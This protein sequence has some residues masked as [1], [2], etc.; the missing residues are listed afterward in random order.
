MAHSIREIN[1]TNQ[2]RENEATNGSSNTRQIESARHLLLLALTV[3]DQWEK[4]IDF[5]IIIHALL[6]TA[7]VAIIYLRRLGMKS[8]NS[9][10]LL[11]LLCAGAN[12]VL[13]DRRES[14]NDGPI[15]NNAGPSSLLSSISHILDKHQGAKDI[16]RRPI[17][18]RTKV[19]TNGGGLVTLSHTPKLGVHLHVRDKR[20]NDAHHL[21]KQV[22]FEKLRLSNAQKRRIKRTFRKHMAKN[23]SARPTMCSLHLRWLK[24]IVSQPKNQTRLLKNLER[25]IGRYVWNKGKRA[26]LCRCFYGLGRGHKIPSG[27]QGDLLKRR[28]H[29]RFML[30]SCN[31]REVDKLKVKRFL[32]QAFKGRRQMNSFERR[33]WMY[34]RHQAQLLAM[35]RSQHVDSEMRSLFDRMLTRLQ[36]KIR[37][38]EMRA[39]L[40]KQRLEIV[41]ALLKKDLDGTMRTALQTRLKLIQTQIK[42]KDTRQIRLAGLAQSILQ[43]RVQLKDLDKML[44]SPLI[45]EHMRNALRSQ[46]KKLIRHISDLEKQQLLMKQR[47]ELNRLIHDSHCSKLTRMALETQVKDIDRQLKKLLKKRIYISDISRRIR[48][49]RRQINVMSQMLKA[50]ELT[51]Y[52]RIVI[53]GHIRHLRCKLRALIRKRAMR[54]QIREIR[55][56]LAFGDVNAHMSNA[57]R[58]QLST[59]ER[60]YKELTVQKQC[61]VRVPALPK[62]CGT[63]LAIQGVA[64]NVANAVSD[65]AARAAAAAA[66]LKFEAQI[67]MAR[68]RDAATRA[69]ANASLHIRMQVMQMEEA[70]RQARLR[71]EQALKLAQERANHARSQV[72]VVIQD[73]RKRGMPVCD[74]P[75]NAKFRQFNRSLRRVNKE[76]E[77]YEKKHDSA[78]KSRKAKDVKKYKD[79]LRQAKLKKAK[80]IREGP[81][82]A[83][84]IKKPCYDIWLP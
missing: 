57:L 35:R 76:V 54:H 80:L 55:R 45:N 71:A 59:L 29:F 46:Q 62:T 60:Q 58:N 13:I 16:G 28:A 83:K 17:F 12:A 81:R 77:K 36:K 43:A 4:R 79:R 64:N 6:H 32:R 66:R 18:R 65:A 75:T 53:R 67:M 50:K 1:V 27:A 34:Q 61:P 37:I 73:P 39:K 63:G 20:D 3:V 70:A 33:L 41:Q 8:F 42:V 10:G 69:G 49:T 23:T 25:D 84:N 21:A 44:A 51:S 68:A 5:G 40:E 30:R 26:D 56:M 15:R 24:D 2:L 22:L 7:I 11:L 82:V 52:L 19:V 31:L 74:A 72:A 48:W 14:S 78:L 9:S 38:W 47:V